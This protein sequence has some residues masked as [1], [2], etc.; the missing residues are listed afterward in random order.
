MA[1][2]FLEL[3]DDDDEEE[4]E[5]RRKRRRRG[6]GGEKEEEEDEEEREKMNEEDNKDKLEMETEEG[7]H[8]FTCL[9]RKAVIPSERKITITWSKDEETK[10]YDPCEN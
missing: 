8:C 1:R 10:S 7:S 5:E 4:E 9:R 3:D 2:V 6:G